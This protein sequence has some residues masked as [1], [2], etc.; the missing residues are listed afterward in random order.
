[1]T[2]VINTFR[3]HKVVK[4]SY[5]QKSI[6]AELARLVLELGLGVLLLTANSKGINQRQHEGMVYV[7]IT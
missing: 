6:L 7:L 1:M 5:N 2:S 4:L 3:A